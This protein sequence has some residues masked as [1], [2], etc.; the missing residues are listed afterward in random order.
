MGYEIKENIILRLWPKSVILLVFWK[1]SRIGQN[2]FGLLLCQTKAQ[3]TNKFWWKFQRPFMLSF[4]DPSSSSWSV[5]TRARHLL[6]L[7]LIYL[8]NLLP[9]NLY[10]IYLTYRANRAAYLSSIICSVQLQNKKFWVPKGLIRLALDTWEYFFLHNF[11]K[12]LNQLLIAQK[13]ALIH[14]LSF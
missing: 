1:K 10:I 6:T 8:L 12:P 13:C 11:S 9:L 14:A 3:W 7:I 4:W 5:V 2:V